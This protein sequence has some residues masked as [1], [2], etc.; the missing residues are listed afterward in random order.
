MPDDASTRGF[1]GTAVGKMV[2]ARQA[3]RCELCGQL[4]PPAYQVDHIEPLWRGGAD[5]ARNLQ[6]LCPN[7]HAAKTQREGAERIDEAQRAARAQQYEERE[8]KYH[9]A[10]A[11]QCLACGRVRRVGTP[12]T[13]C[14]AIERGPEPPDAV[15]GRLLALFARRP[16][17][18]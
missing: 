3:W 4:L 1:V 17:A 9:S 11:V 5:E 16:P 12:H 7:C 15:E 14:W 6:A 13:I 10:K 8:D 18:H 2:A